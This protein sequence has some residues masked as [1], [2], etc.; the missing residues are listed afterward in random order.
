MKRSKSINLERM[1]KGSRLFTAKP[2]ALGVASALM[3]GC[4]A[5]EKVHIVESVQQCTQLDG[6]DQ[7]SCEA[8]YQKA[9][10]EAKRTAPRYVNLRACENE[11]GEANCVSVSENRGGN[12]FIPAMAG[13]MVG[14]VLHRNDPHYYGYGYSPYQ[15]LFSYS[16]SR[17][18]AA[19]HLTTADGMKIGR[20]GSS[21]SVSKSS[22]KPKPSVTRTM[23][24][25]GF[26]SKV[27]AKSSWGG[28]KSGGGWGG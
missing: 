22:F 8:A 1:R 11:F 9:L 6:Y 14:Q 17:Y 2:L 15:P 25:G 18:S 4:T 21:V 10:Q 13:F 7:A 26:G 3:L 24:R 23:S 27:S 19:T 28:G 12:W 20:P 16:G 5:K